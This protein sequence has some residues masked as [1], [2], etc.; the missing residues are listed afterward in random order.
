MGSARRFREIGFFRAM[1]VIMEGDAEM[2]PGASVAA[3]GRQLPQTRKSAVVWAVVFCA[4]GLMLFSG[5]STIKSWFAS[6]IEKTAQDL[7]SD[8]MDAYESRDYKDAI[9]AFEQ[10]K[11]WYPF[12]KYT[13]LAELKIADANY[14]LGNYEEAIY[15][16]ESFESLHPRNEAIPYVIYQVGLCYFEQIDTVDRDQTPA[17]EALKTFQRLERRYPGNVYAIKARTHIDRCYK[18][19]SGHELYVGKFYFKTGHYRAALYRFKSVVE[20]YPDVGY[21]LEALDYIR[22]CR[23]F[24]AEEEG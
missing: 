10:L 23:I 2:Q 9:K 6:D 7:A 20:N 24:M 5:C 1:D 4:L 13:A 16:Y 15:A 8:G 3:E 14:K 11:D 17:R 12:S 18:S 21:H 22:Q 19:L